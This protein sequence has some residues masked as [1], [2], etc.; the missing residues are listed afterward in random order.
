MDLR[1]PA[2]LKIFDQQSRTIIFNS[3]K[4]ETTGNTHYFKISKEVS[5]I[6][7]MLKALYELNVQ[8]VLVEGGSMLLQSFI[9]EKLWDEIRKIENE[10]LEIGNGLT[11]P[12]FNGALK[13]N[14]FDLLDDKI[15]IYKPGS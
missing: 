2:S 11:A 12:V 1:L 10:K 4:H 15:E 13:V 5:V 6:K 7:Q 8:T 14:E 3:V 9:D